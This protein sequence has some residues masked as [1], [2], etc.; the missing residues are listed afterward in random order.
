MCIQDRL[1]S[2]K[3]FGVFH[4]NLNSSYRHSSKAGEFGFVGLMDDV[5]AGR[6]LLD[7]LCRRILPRPSRSIAMATLL[8][9]TDVCPR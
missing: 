5:L 3:V 7:E 9:K 6:D 8:E 2:D 1:V 4:G